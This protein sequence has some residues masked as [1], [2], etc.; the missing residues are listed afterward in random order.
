MTRPLLYD[1]YDT[2]TTRATWIEWEGDIPIIT[3]TQDT[4]P[5][6]E[7]NKRAAAEFLGTNRDDITRVA[8]IPNVIVQRLMQTGVWWDQQ[9][10]NKWL[11][12]PANRWLRTDDGR[13]L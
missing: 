7:A 9:A 3:Y 4:R 11:N 5:I 2:V 13:T 10:L 1:A 6:I 8:C 12:D